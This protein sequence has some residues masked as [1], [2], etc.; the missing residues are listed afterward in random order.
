MPNTNSKKL[1]IFVEDCFPLNLKTIYNDVVAYYKKG[2]NNFYALSY[3]HN[4][5]DQCVLKALSLLKENHS[6]I[7]FNLVVSAVKDKEHRKM[8]A[9]LTKVDKIYYP[10][11]TDSDDFFIAD[12]DSILSYVV[13]EKPY[14]NDCVLKI[15]TK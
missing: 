10:N 9:K 3:Q 11:D 8:M 7:H 2:Y 6:D 1:A 4:A 5:N 12:M 14:I 13:D 15:S